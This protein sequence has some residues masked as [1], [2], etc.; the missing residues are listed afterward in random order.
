MRVWISDRGAKYSG[1]RYRVVWIDPNTRRERSKSFKLKR[2]ADAFQTHTENGMRSGPYRDPDADKKIFSVLAESWMKSRKKIRDSTRNRDQRDLNTWILPMWGNR[3]IGSIRREEVINWVDALETGTAPH[4]Y[5]ERAVG[6]VSTGLSARSVTGLHKNFSAAL[7]HG[8]TLKWLVVNE[9]KGV[10]LSKPDSTRRVYLKPVQV[11]DLVRRIRDVGGD[12][13][14]TLVQFLAYSGA[15]IGEALS[16][17]VGDV[18]FAARRVRIE[19]TWTDSNGTIKLGPPKSGKSRRVPLHGFLLPELAELIGD[20]PADAWLFE[21][22]RGGHHS[23]N[24]WRSRIWSRATAGSQF[25]LMGLVPH[26][27]RHTAASMAIASGANVKV[28]QEMLGHASA[29]ETLDTYADLWPDQLD[30]VADKVDE[31]RRAA[32]QG[33]EHRDEDPGNGL[34]GALAA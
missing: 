16:L 12:S 27:L 21:A 18:D 31:A 25:Q 32:L 1:L 17:R 33:H 22:P 5:A 34:A 28:V 7:S 15:R 19:R 2:D 4:E 13:N 14:A 26:G 9:A 11:E 20:R 8:V 30:E 29:V 3:E 23:P 24:N 10:E 6:K